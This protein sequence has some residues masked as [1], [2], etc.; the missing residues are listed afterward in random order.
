M[1]ESSNSGWSENTLVATAEGNLSFR[2]FIDKNIE[3]IDALSHDMKKDD[4]IVTKMKNIRL[5]RKN[6]D[7]IKI[8]FNDGSEKFIECS[9]D[10]NIYLRNLKKTMVRDIKVG[11]ILFGMNPEIKVSRIL[12]DYTGKNVYNGTVEESHTYFIYYDEVSAILS[13]D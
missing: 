3:E 12:H 2:H 6:A 9:S 5:A 8:H 13:S 11:D 7:T 1:R 10:N 4:V